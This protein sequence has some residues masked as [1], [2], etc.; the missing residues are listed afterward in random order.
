MPSTS[1]CTAT[2]TTG[3]DTGTGA[4]KKVLVAK[5]KFSAVSDTLGH[6][7]LRSVFFFLT[8]C[9]SVLLFF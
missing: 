5:M 4:C 7:V 2:W 6:S 1:T 3:T 8:K 9:N